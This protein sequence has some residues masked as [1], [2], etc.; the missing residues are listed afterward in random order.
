[1]T[2]DLR[3]VKQLRGVAA[4]L[5]GDFDLQQD[6][7]Q[8]MFVHLTRVTAELPGRTS[9]WYVKGCEFHA[10][11][12]LNRGRSIDSIKRQENLVPLGPTDDADD[13]SWFNPDAV[14][15]L[16]LRS[17]LITR[18]ILRLLLPQLTGIQQHVLFLLL[19]GFAV[20]EIAREL[21][22]SHPTIIKH[23]KK[24]AR[25]TAV[26]LVDASRSETAVGVNT[27]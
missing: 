26:L 16:D 12:Y 1:M 6:L 19:H 7:L 14:D 15:P 10:R 2:E 5:T 4:K 11:D 24:I 25:T 13:S 22:L 21:Q 20:R 8:E 18:D 17:E 23:R 3:I 27:P 9:S